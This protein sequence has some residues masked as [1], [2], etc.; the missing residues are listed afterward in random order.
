[1]AWCLGEM[2]LLDKARSADVWADVPVSC[3]ELELE[4]LESFC[5]EHPEAGQRI[6]R[7]LSAAA[8]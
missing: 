5:R 1:M 7:N 6:M 3:L 4:K 8:G 2:A